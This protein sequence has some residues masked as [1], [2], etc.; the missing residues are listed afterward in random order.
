MCGEKFKQHYC[1]LA[2]CFYVQIEGKPEQANYSYSQLE[3][4]VIYFNLS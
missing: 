1:H 4:I 2:M 3:Y